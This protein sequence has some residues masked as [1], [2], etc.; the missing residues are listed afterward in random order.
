MKKILFL[1]LIF[2]CCACSTQP[3]H[4]FATYNVRIVLAAD[5]GEKSWYER[6]PYL[7]QNILDNDIDIIGMQE[8]TGNNADSVTGCSQLED[9]QQGLPEYACIAND[10]QDPYYSFNAVFYRKDKYECESWSS[11]FLNETPDEPAKGWGAEYFRRCLV[12]RMRVKATGEEFYF[13]CTHA[14]YEPMAACEGEA[15]LLSDTLPKIT[16]DLPMVLVGDLNH[17]KK[18]KPTVYQLYRRAFEDSSD[19]DYPTYQNW[20]CADSPDFGGAEIDY[21]FYRYL[22]PVG[23]KVVTEDFGR[24]VPPSDHFLVWADFRLGGK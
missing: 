4:R 23:R 14:D 20:R 18:D 7:I 11:F 10:R 2:G 24:N 17:D 22:T 1:L 21:L 19:S 16:G 5:Q 6:R 3:V 15:R 9:L 12:A 13:C 8:V